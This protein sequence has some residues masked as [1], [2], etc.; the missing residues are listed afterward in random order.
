MAAHRLTPEELARLAGLR[1]VSDSQPGITRRR[2]GR[3]FHYRF[4]SG[5]KVGDKRHLERIESLVIPPA[6]TGVWICRD[7]LGHLQATGRDDRGRKQF[8]YHPRWREASDL[9]KFDRLARLHSALPRI[10][11]QVVRDLRRRKPGRE[12]A[13]ALIVRLLDLTGMRIGNEAYMNANGSRGLTTLDRQH[14]QMS[15]SL[16]EF[17]F[18]GK[19]GK[20]QQIQVS[21]RMVLRGLKSI[22][23][24]DAQSL[25]VYR[26]EEGSRT[27]DAEDVNDYLRK[28]S[29]ID[30]TAKDFRTWLACAQAAASLYEHHG[31]ESPSQRK[32]ILSRVVKKVAGRLGNT[33]AVCRK[34]YIDPRLLQGYESGMLCDRFRAFRRRRSKWLNPEDQILRHALTALAPSSQAVGAREGSDWL[35]RKLRAVR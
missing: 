6:W 31:V 34:S 1:Y 8:I 23:D 17:S 13:L 29:A 35:S 10:R 5:R 28:I 15:D 3:G 16:A 21:D 11:R 25:F 7:P 9:A 27:I 2:C 4:S 22:A 14:L 18:P 26:D 33:P 32:R 19:S 24:K 12:K 30:V 20:R